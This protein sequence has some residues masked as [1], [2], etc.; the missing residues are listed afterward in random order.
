MASSS[1]IEIKKFNGKSFELWKLKVDKDQRII[2]DLG[3]TTIGTSVEYWKKLDQKAKSTIWLCLSDS[4]LL[5]VSGEATT[6][7]L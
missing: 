5:N 2:V 1:K 6:K 7:A 4:I 3:T